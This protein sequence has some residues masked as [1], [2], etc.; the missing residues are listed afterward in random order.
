MISRRDS[1]LGR[2]DSDSDLIFLSQL[3]EIFDQVVGDLV[4]L[5]ASSITMSLFRGVCLGRRTLC[6][7]GTFGK[8]QGR[9]NLQWRGLA[10]VATDKQHGVCP[11]FHGD[12]F[13]Y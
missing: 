1:K 2:Y 13:E 12:Q 4:T 7:A 6:G 9:A 8:I 11:Q 3:E 5:L 10:S